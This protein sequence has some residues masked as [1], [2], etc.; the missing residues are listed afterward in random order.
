MNIKSLF[1]A[2]PTLS[3]A[4]MILRKINEQD[5]DEVFA[6]YSNDLIFT[7]C[8]I[9]TKKNKAVVLRSIGHF[10]RDFRKKSRIK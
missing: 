10:E 6:I 2:F 8:G 9:F 5:I 7:Y 4:S 3:S 1:G